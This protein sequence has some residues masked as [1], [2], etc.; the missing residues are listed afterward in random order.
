MLTEQGEMLYR[1]ANEMMLKL[2][3]GPGAAPGG[4]TAIGN[5]PRD[6]HRSALARPGW[7]AA[8]RV[9]RALSGDRLQ[10]ILENEELD[11]SMR[12]ADVAIRLQKPSQPDLIQ[13][14][15]FTDHFHIYAAPSYV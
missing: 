15:L 13:R 4:G 3:C 1:A 6:H 5:A 10:V 9:R 7:R 11:L 12:Q 14:R 2:E 8:A